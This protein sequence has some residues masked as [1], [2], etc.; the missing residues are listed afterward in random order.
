MPDYDICTRN[1]SRNIKT[2]Q[3]LE[4]NEINAP[5][6]IVDKT[7]RQN[8]KPTSEITLRYPTS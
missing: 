1:K 2:R 3:T 8:K 6:K 4:A 5:S 7:K